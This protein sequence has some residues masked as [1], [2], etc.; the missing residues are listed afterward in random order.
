MRATTLPLLHAPGISNGPPLRLAESEQERDGEIIA[1]TAYAGSH[2][3]YRIADGI[4]DLLNDEP[5]RI[6]P[7]QRSNFAWPTARYYEQ[8]WR[9]HSL[10]LLADEQ[11]S[12][13]REIAILNEWVVPERGGLYVDI[14]TSHGLYARNIAAQMRRA[15]ATGTVI[16]LDIAP[17]MLRRAAQLIAAKGYTT[18][19]LV[20][21][22]AQAL[23]L[24]DGAA[25]GVVN[26]GTFNEMGAQGEALAEARRV[27]KPDGVFF[28]MSLLAGRTGAGRTAQ[29]ALGASGII[30]PTVDETNA[31]YR[32][33]RLTITDQEW[34]GIVLLTRAVRS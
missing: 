34:H 28:C 31:L 18:I 1:G 24:A 22:R 33:A 25:N 9:V 4:L 13:D 8:V 16:A 19:D 15:S 11:F 20:R 32:D 7:A 21:A 10:S 3:P 5:L 27:L 26:G 14:G 30:F 12:I 29:R 2:G 17:G 23:P 6:S